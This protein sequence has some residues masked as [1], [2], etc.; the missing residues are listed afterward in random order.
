[1]APR[2]GRENLCSSR[3]SVPHPGHYRL[4]Y[5][6]CK[7]RALLLLVYWP[8]GNGV[9]GRLRGRLHCHVGGGDGERDNVTLCSRE[10]ER[11]RDQHIG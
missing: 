4:G 9:F 6:G 10:R 8:T 5:R 1:V 11:E 7:I 3:S 2:A